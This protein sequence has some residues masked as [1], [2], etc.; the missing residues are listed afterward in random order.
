VGAAQSSGQVSAVSGPSQTPSPQRFL[1]SPA[2]FVGRAGRVGVDGAVGLV[3][4]DVG[5]LSDGELE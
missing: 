3:R 2:G 5:L 1:L 4:V